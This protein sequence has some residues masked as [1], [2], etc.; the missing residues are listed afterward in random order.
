MVYT[1]RAET[2]AV[3]CGTSHV[4]AVSTP[5]RCIF[6]NVPYKAVVIHSES[7]VTTAQS[8]C[9]EAENKRYYIKTTRELSELRSCVKVEVAVLGS[10][11]LKSLMVSVGVKQQ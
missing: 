8:V 4:S 7:H 10:P 1:E 6:K 3:S 2:A 11:S 5:L 9:S